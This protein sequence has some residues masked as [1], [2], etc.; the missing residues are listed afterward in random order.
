M[1][2]DAATSVAAILA[3]AGGLWLGWTWL[4]PLMALAGAALIAQWSAGL[5]RSSAMALVD[6]TAEP[7]LRQ[8]VAAAIESDGDAKLA[9]LHVWQVGPQAW[10]ATLSVVADHPLAATDYHQ[11]LKPLRQV[12]HATIEVHRCTGAA[13]H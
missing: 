13:A 8:A 1:L 9:D 7:A 10:S 2:A 12:R 5:L 4:D 3:L 6:A 11:R